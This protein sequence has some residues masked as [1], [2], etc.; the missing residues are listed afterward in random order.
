LIEYEDVDNGD[1]ALEEMDVQYDSGFNTQSQSYKHGHCRHATRDHI[2]C[3]CDKT[4]TLNVHPD[5]DMCY[6]SDVLNDCN[7]SLNNN[8]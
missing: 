6:G 4:V 5:N 7:Y 1:V 2:C 3:F 8:M